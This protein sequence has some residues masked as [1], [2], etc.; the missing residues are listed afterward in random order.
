M[1]SGMIRIA[2]LLFATTIALGTVA[3]ATCSNSS[4]SGT[5]G[6]VASGTTRKNQPTATV[7]Q[8]T[9]IPGT[10]DG[11]L[12]G[13]ETL[14]VNGIV[15]TSPI[16]GTYSIAASCAGTATINAP[17]ITTAHFRFEVVSGGHR[18]E[19][20]QTDKGAIVFGYAMAQGNAT[21]T[22]QGI[23]TKYG[24]QN[25]GPVVGFGP[26]A[27]VGRLR[28]D[29]SGGVRGDESG[30]Q[31]GSIVK[32]VPLSGSYAVNSD[33][34][35]SAVLT[36]EGTAATNFNFVVVDNGNTLLA[37]ETDPMTVVTGVLR[38]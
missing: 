2:S 28:F 9:V 25:S 30:S 24:F 35:G 13:T 7:G 15:T 14:D 5:Y 21:C 17:G 33:C 20:V 1:F 34:T 11:T 6:F 10:P 36:P 23:G 19:T 37:I 32:G 18:I 3:S 26:I 8:L 16:T 12:S 38:H 4:V 29:G 27:F 31:A 22:N